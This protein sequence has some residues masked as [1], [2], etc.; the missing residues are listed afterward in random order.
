MRF[1]LVQLMGTEKDIA[2]N[3]T[4]P[5]LPSFITLAVVHCL[6]HNKPSLSPELISNN[7]IFNRLKCNTN[8]L[9]RV[10]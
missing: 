2:V 3:F 10:V 9:Y 7:P 8:C 4:A 6:Q 1:I 5:R